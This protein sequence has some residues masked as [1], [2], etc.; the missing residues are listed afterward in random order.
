MTTDRRTFVRL[1]MASAVFSSVGVAAGETETAY[2]AQSTSHLFGI[3]TGYFSPTFEWLPGSTR[4][5]STIVLT[6][7]AINTLVTKSDSENKWWNKRTYDLAPFV[8]HLGMQTK[9]FENYRV[10]EWA[11]VAAK[12]YTSFMS[13]LKWAVEAGL[14]AATVVSEIPPLVSLTAGALALGISLDNLAVDFANLLTGNRK[15]NELLQTMQHRQIA[16][17][18]ISHSLSLNGHHLVETVYYQDD[19]ETGKPI[20]TQDY[21]LRQPKNAMS[22]S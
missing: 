10:P 11:T 9:S 3:P 19:Y 12:S 14:C 7:D 4:S 8:Q 18:F 21:Q 15:A 16:H 22:A 1:A 5:G 17:G 6:A 13:L 2:D 20:W